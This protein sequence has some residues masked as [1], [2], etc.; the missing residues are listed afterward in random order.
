M[1]FK[2]IGLLLLVFITA[3]L[4]AQKPPENEKKI[5][6]SPDGKLYVNKDASVYLRIS[7]SPEEDTSGYLLRSDKTPEYTNPMY[8]DAEGLN[9][10]RS[11]WKIDPETKQYVLPKQDVV[12]NVYADSKPPETSLVISKKDKRTEKNKIFVGET[13]Q[14]KFESEDAL[15]GVEETYFSINQSP[16]KKYKQPIAIDEEKRFTI[17][18]Y[19]VDHVGNAEQP[20]ENTIITDLSAPVTT[21]NIKGDRHKNVVSEHS[22]ISLSAT[23]KTTGV[24]R[25]LYSIDSNESKVYRGPIQAGRLKEGEHTL[26]YYSIDKVNNQEKKQ[27]YN[28]FVDKTPPRVVEELMGNTFVANGKEYF[29]GKNR[30]KFISMDNKAGVKK[31]L[32]SINN[33][34]FREYTKPFYLKQSGN[35]SITTRAI[36]HVNNERVSQKLTNRSNVS[37]VDLSGPELNYDFRGPE[38]SYRDTAFITNKTKIVLKGKDEESGFNKIE[39]VVGSDGES[40]TYE[41]PFTMKK[42]GIYSVQYT[43]YDNL[44]NTSI[45]EFPCIVDNKGPEIFPRFSTVSNKIK[46]IKGQKYRVFPSHTMLFIAATDRKSGFE[47][48]YY[49]L[50]G[51]DKK[52][53]N[54]I[55]GGFQKGKYELQVTAIDKLGNKNNKTLHFYIE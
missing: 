20:G 19:S 45:D 3:D 49:S 1:N 25:T 48:M 24:V 35:L 44:G 22:D 16:Y 38:F 43:G 27:V 52:L 4:V 33:G 37:Y 21:H 47:R 53:Y 18:Y 23:D 9:T 17:K 46:T 7:H 6:R 54:Q 28:F 30:L 55:I 51:G 39:Y 2:F 40:R 10:I 42:E 14:L 31:I 5:Y 8:F 15:S 12:F 34:P 11:P 29:S 32:Y 50:N 36:D 13:F 41:N 26:T